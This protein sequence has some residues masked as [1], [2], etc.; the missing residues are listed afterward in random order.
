MS[1]SN[2]FQFLAFLNLKEQV[3][4]LLLNLGK[5]NVDNADFG[6]VDVSPFNPAKMMFEILTGSA[7]KHI[8]YHTEL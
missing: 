1:K 5:Y 7:V 4:M 8:M 2:L 3:S 6:L